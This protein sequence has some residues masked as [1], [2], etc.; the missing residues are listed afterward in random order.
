MAFFVTKLARTS[1]SSLDLMWEKHNQEFDILRNRDAF[2]NPKQPGSKTWALRI[3]GQKLC[4]KPL[5]V[6]VLVAC[7]WACVFVRVRACLFLHIY[8]RSHFRR[9][10]PRKQ[11]RIA[12]RH[13]RSRSS[14]R[15]K[16][17][18][19]RSPSSKST[20]QS[21]EPSCSPP[22][23]SESSKDT[24]APEN[25]G[26]DSSQKDPLEDIFVS[27]FFEKSPIAFLNPG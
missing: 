23:E 8:F 13:S 6:C 24:E 1:L 7:V 15:P 11:S 20:G 10:C 12:R 9:H 18:R 4:E 25:P 14:R 27:N 17:S 16:S 3:K 5:V 22:R 26:S 2:Q 19:S 21:T